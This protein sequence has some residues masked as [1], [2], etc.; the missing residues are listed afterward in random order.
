MLKNLEQKLKPYIMIQRLKVKV[1]KECKVK[2]KSLQSLI[3]EKTCT[4]MHAFQPSLQ[5]VCGIVMF[6]WFAMCRKWRSTKFLP[7]CHRT[8]GQ[9]LD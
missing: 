8:F 4:D 2:V 6:D 1:V 3:K 5:S 7:T 9:R